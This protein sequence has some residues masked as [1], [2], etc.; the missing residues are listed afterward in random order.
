MW[1]SRVLPADSAPMSA[2]MGAIALVVRG[3]EKSDPG[4][5]SL[6]HA[7]ERIGIGHPHG[8]MSEQDGHRSHRRSEG[9]EGQRAKARRLSMQHPV[10]PQRP[11]QGRRQ[12]QAKQH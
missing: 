3:A 5:N 11:S 8:R 10:Q 12:N 9:H 6:N 1:E 4:Q 7:T 2:T